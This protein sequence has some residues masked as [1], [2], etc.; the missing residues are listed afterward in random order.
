MNNY[1][2]VLPFFA[3]ETEQG[4]DKNIYC[5]RLAPGTNIADVQDSIKN[6]QRSPN[7]NLCWQLEDQGLP[8]ERQIHNR[9]FDHY[10]DRD[11]ELIEQ[12]AVTQGHS[13]RIIKLNTSNLCNGTCITCGS[14]ASTAWAKLEKI[15]IEYQAM[16]TSKLNLDLQNIIQLSFVGGEP[17]LERQNFDVLQRLIQLGNTNCFV[18]I[19]TNGSIQLNQAQL[20]ILASFPNLNICLSIDGVGPQF[21][22]IRWPLKW[23][24]LQH[25]IIQFKK[26]AQHI[27]VSCMISNLN[28]FYYTELVEFFQLHDIAYLCKQIEFPPYFAPGNLPDQFKQQ[29]LARNSKY[30]DQVSAFLNLGRND[31]SEKFWQEIDRQDQLKG[32]S[33]QD[34]LPEL[35]ATRT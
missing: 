9:T 3:Y 22:Y 23:S 17:L 27:S 21:E 4:T 33:I 24:Q 30:H 26:I 5:C 18:S 31:L 13:A 16:Q 32:I 25:N 19:V 20:D 7:C 2:C 12:D 11:L 6:K 8:S 14:G 1:F 10:A 15:P 35:A 29:V 28:V 34:Y